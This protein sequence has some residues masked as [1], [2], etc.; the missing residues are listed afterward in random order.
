[1]EVSGYYRKKVLWEVIDDHVVE[2]PKDK[3]EIGI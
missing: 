1:M 3:N 2:D